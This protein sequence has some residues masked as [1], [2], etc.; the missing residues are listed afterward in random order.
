[1]VYLVAAFGIVPLVTLVVLYRALN[2][3]SAWAWV[4]ITYAI[5]PHPHVIWEAVANQVSLFLGPPSFPGDGILPQTLKICLLAAELEAS[6]RAGRGWW[7][8]K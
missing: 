4:G 3:A 1:M 7:A 8:L 6:F 5:G 2:Y